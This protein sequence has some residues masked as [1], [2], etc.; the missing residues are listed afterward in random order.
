MVIERI[1]SGETSINVEYQ[2]TLAKQRNQMDSVKQDTLNEYNQSG[3]AGALPEPEQ[4]QFNVEIELKKQNQ[5]IQA[6]CKNR[7]TLRSALVQLVTSVETLKEAVAAFGIQETLDIL[8][9]MDDIYNINNP[10]VL[11]ANIRKEVD[12]ILVSSDSIYSKSNPRSF[13]EV[14]RH[15]FSIQA[16]QANQ[17]IKNACEAIN[18][19]RGKHYTDKE[20]KLLLDWMSVDAQSDIFAIDCNIAAFIDE[21]S[22]VHP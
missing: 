19:E 1:A 13:Q 14:V 11:L 15:K 18:I 3:F 12:L 5:D 4:Q 6:D 17:R 21:S 8:S 7:N 10:L 16:D 2:K 20:K 9:N 22:D